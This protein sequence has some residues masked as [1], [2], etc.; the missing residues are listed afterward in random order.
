[1]LGVARGLSVLIVSLAL[2]AL[3]GGGSAMAE[4]PATFF[5]VVTKKWVAYGP[6]AARRSGAS[7]IKREVVALNGPHAP[8]TIIV[9][10]SERRLYYTLGDGKAIKYGVG[11]GR[12]GFQWSGTHRVTRKA[13]WPSWTPPPAMIKRRPELAAYARGMPGGPDN[14]LGARALYIGSTLYRIHGTNE[15]W[16][17]GQAVSSGC[18]R[19]AN[20]DVI[21]LY[22]RVGVGTRV[23]VR[24]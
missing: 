1:M 18:I 23:V 17:I 9:S 5:D 13:E 11:V 12:E 15:A 16:S 22:N 21:D 7:P 19:M 2:L 4:G 24:H 14:P 3:A 6:A 20:E 10:T 8:N